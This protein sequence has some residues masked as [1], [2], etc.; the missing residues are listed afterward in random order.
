MLCRVCGLTSPMTKSSDHQTSIRQHSYA[1]LG[2]VLSLF[3]P[4]CNVTGNSDAPTLT[5]AFYGY[6]STLQGLTLQVRVT[7][8]THSV[9]WAGA[10]T[11]SGSHPQQFEALTLVAG[12]DVTAEAVLRTAE[13][14]EVARVSLSFPAQVDWAYGLGFQAGGRNPDASGFC[15]LAPAKR[16][17]PNFPD[18]TVFLWYAGLPR[19]AVC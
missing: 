6:S 5:G 15:H 18:D 1:I 12:R 7:T 2:L 11:A 9:S 8:A 3:S 19:G 4:A 10:A 13:G 14:Q 16:A 17:I